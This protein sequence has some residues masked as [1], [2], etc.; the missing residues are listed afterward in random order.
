MAGLT[1][2]QKAAKAALKNYMGLASDEVLLVI[3]DNVKRDV[4]LT[5]YDMANKMCREALYIE[6]EARG[7]H[8]EAPPE[9][10]AKLMKEVDVIV[11][12]TNK[13]ITHTKAR[14]EASEQG[15]RIGTMPGIT[16]ETM[17]RCLS[18]EPDETVRLTEKV[19]KKFKG[20]RKI[21][22]TTQIGTDITME[23]G[24]RKIIPSTGVLR[25]ISDSGNLPS[26]EVYFAP[27]EEK[28]NGTIIFDGS[29]SG[30]GLLKKIIRVDIVDGV[31]Q[32]ITGSPDARVLSRMLNKYGKMGRA[33]GEFGIGTNPHAKLCGN[34]LEDEKVMGTVHFAFGNNI[35][36]GGKIDVNN[37]LDGL[38]TS[39]T[40][41]FDDLLVMEKGKI[42]F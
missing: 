39:P 8:G 16:E 23:V 14:R 6:M 28:T 17:I 19:A 9:P 42:L 33:L 30:L 25:T 40:V 37:H 27:V 34:I 32:D 3:S 41:Y 20:V 12:P 21:R 29:V 1:K 13:S 18:G 10:I 11:A 24:D 15:V 4:G 2:F 26:G 35:G 7:N 38:V 22:V 31:A 36:M 5:I